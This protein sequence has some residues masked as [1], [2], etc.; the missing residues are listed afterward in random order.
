MR[1]NNK[2]NPHMTTR[3][4]YSDQHT[5]FHSC[6]SIIYLS[7]IVGVSADEVKVETL[8]DIL[9]ILKPK[10]DSFVRITVAR[11]TILQDSIAVFKRRSFDLNDPVR[12]S[13]ESELAVDAGGP[14]REYFTLLMKEL[15]SPSN[16]ILGFHVTSPISNVQNQEAYRNFTFI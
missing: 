1:T 5:V 7:F 6:L 11:G 12:I 3:V 8:K 16:P 9:R 10:E 14:K 2:L 13:F 15:L 4:H